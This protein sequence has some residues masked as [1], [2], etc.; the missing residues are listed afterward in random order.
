MIKNPKI[1]DSDFS[2]L[3]LVS[4]LMALYLMK[5]LNGD[6]LVIKLLKN[7]TISKKVFKSTVIHFCIDKYEIELLNNYMDMLQ[8]FNDNEKIEILDEMLLTLERV[9]AGKKGMFSKENL[10]NTLLINKSLLEQKRLET[11]FERKENKY[12]VKQRL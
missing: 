2:F 4:P 11:C 10:I 12:K 5:D 1:F 7:K 8:V 9:N 6:S 3:N